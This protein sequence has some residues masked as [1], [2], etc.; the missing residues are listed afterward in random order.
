M[1]QHDLQQVNDEWEKI[2]KLLE[3]LKVFKATTNIISGI[4]YPFANLF[5]GE[6][7]RIK[8]L[9]DV[10]SESLDDFVKIMVENMKERFTKYWGECNLLMTIGLMVDPR[11]KMRVVEIAF[12]KMFPSDLVR[13]NIS[14]VKNIM[15]QLFD[16]YLRMYC[17]TCN[18]EE[19]GECAFPMDAHG[20]VTS[21]GLSE[22][23][24]DVFSGG[25][26]YTACEK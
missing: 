12:P 16:E 22:L 11:L 15:Y 3:I 8:E 18:V 25:N 23:L 13:E 17:S 14:K 20:D 5:L 4:E 7:Q 24:Q 21:S 9:L 19:S 26:F 2:E 1:V 10:K 6:V